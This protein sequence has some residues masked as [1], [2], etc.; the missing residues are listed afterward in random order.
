MIEEEEKIHGGK[1][2]KAKGSER[3]GKGTDLGENEMGEEK[4]RKGEEHQD[5]TNGTKK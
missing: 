3:R 5:T 1:K 2:N 4:R